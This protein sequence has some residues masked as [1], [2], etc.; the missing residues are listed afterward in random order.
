VSKP[1]DRA[2]DAAFEYVRATADALDSDTAR[3]EREYE[4]A[5]VVLIE[6][7]QAQV[8][9][10]DAMGQYLLAEFGQAELDRRDTEERWLRDLRQY[11]G[12]YDPEVLA[13]IDKNR[14]RVFIRKTRVKV[15]TVDA[16]MADLVFPAGAT[17]NFGISPTPKPRLSG[18]QKAEIRKRLQKLGQQVD[19]QLFD[20]VVLEW[21]TERAKEMAKTIDDQLVEAGYKKACLA[22]MHSGNLYGVG[23]IKG[24]LVE[25]R[26]RTRF[27]SVNG[28]WTPQS[29][30]YIVPFIEH[31]PL[32]RF[33]PD[34]GA[35]C[36]EQM[37]YVYE[38]HEKSAHEMAD[39]ASRKTF[40]KQRIADHVLA[41]P[42]GSGRLRYID[43]E[44][45]QIGEREAQLGSLGGKYQV[46][47]RWG[48]L[49]GEQ[50]C[51]VGVEVPADRKHES[52]FSNV[53]ML[54]D[55]Q[56]I[57]AV[58]QPINGQTWPYHAYHFDKDESTFF[59]EGLASLIRDDQA[60]L[61]AAT[62]LM[63]DDAA[64]TVG[65]ML[66]VNPHLLSSLDG[67]NEWG[68]W[69]TWLRNNVAPGQRAVTPINLT[70]SLSELAAMA[71]HFENNADEVSAVPRYM[72]GENATNGAAGT[73]S[74]LSM[75][76]GN[77][78]I[79]VKD[80]IASWD[81]GV[82]VSFI[83]G[84]Y[85]WNMQFNPDDAIK[86]DFDVSA[87]ATASLVAKEVRARQLN[88]FATLTANPLDAPFIKR[89]K[90]NRQ[91]AEALELIDV[92]KT[93]DEIKAENESPAAKMQTQ[94]Q[95]QLAQ[96]QL[97]EA[98]AKVAKLSAEADLTKQKVGEILANIDLTIAKAVEARVGAA[99]A[100]LQAGG[101]ATQTPFIAPAGDE[102][103]RS[104]GWKDQTPDPSI[105]QLNTAPVQA[106]GAAPQM[107]GGPMPQPA[108]PDQAKP[109]G[110]EGADRYIDIGSPG[111]QTGMKGV[112]EGIETTRIDGA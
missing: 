2:D 31:V 58:L 20:K 15:K 59:N 74:G 33:Y 78:N 105:A 30:S 42:N 25:R 84:M 36:L 23:I 47:E 102:I 41:Y 83:K 13:K 35:T 103:L 44:L 97:G 8:Q 90:L 69:K 45:R 55:G 76:I 16:R 27:V 51:Q 56:V 89:D 1:H 79:I 61:N 12:L 19:R 10:L 32:W 95:V 77:V 82:T 24:P 5:A 37:R 80:Q 39:L 57:R 46:L 67:I 21:A 72:S 64:M 63:L 112:H 3:D 106:G 85:H 7:D 54:S 18:D 6:Q 104:A 17:R 98:Q 71:Q 75:L 70:G 34:M 93:D 91:R 26:V 88:D 9:P 52:F 96:A 100:A 29:E 65:T 66:E 50:L 22:A 81:E 111:P 28:K 73:S 108:E 60:M 87:T 92:V 11:R 86:G 14:S 99:Y 94:M 109:P 68:P 62:R 110:P 107:Q 40:N 48:W 101:V 49:S 43:S 53:W 38:L 4:A